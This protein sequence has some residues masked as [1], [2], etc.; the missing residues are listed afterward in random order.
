MLEAPT[1]VRAKQ[2]AM[3]QEAA[4]PFAFFPL[5]KL[6]LDVT[7]AARTIRTA[8]YF[9]V[10]FAARSSFP[11]SNRKSSPT[12]VGLPSSNRSFLRERGGCR[13]KSESEK[14]DALPAA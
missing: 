2:L 10:V 3:P 12:E 6:H 4:E 9:L 1:A 7:P 14:R 8:H 11:A 5:S 13:P